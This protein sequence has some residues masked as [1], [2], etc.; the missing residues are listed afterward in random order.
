META[1]I[2]FEIAKNQIGIDFDSL[3]KQLPEE[4][5]SLP[6]QVLK[7]INHDWI[8]QEVLFVVVEAGRDDVCPNFDRLKICG[9]TM[10]EW[11]LMAG[12]QCQ[13]IVLKDGDVLETLRSLQTDKKIMAIFYN[14]APLLDRNA[15]C[16]ILD[17]F[18]SKS[19]NFLQLARGFIVKTE[20]LKNNP[21][22][23]SGV[24]GG[25]EDEA[26]LVA[27]SASVLSYVHKY[28]NRKI[29]NYHI[30]NGVVIFGENTVFIDA[31]CE[32]EGG[33]VIHPNNVIE[34]QSIISAGCV[35]ESGNIVK[36][37]IISPNCILKG[38]FIQNSKIGAGHRI[39]E[40]E[41]IINQE[42]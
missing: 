19:I 26:L 23:I 8:N 30:A 10:T 35:L 17:Y 13:K 5:S 22:F 38:T 37:S 6:S 11:V 31:D 29:L 3:E 28:L 39:D 4:S 33:V 7:Q 18:S 20:F 34:G 16:R 32:I 42:I 12:G 15:F 1:E 40:A 21:S 41:A 27:D 2:E 25:Y 36:N 9:K 14:D 24:T